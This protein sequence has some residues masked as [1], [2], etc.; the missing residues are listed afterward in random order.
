[1]FQ[2]QIERCNMIVVPK[3]I[4][5][6]FKMEPDQ[7]LKVG[8]SLPVKGSGV[9]YFYAK[10]NKEGRIRIPKIIV[11]VLQGKEENLL[12]YFLEATVEPA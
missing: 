9:Q 8:V 11:M 5:W 3:M 7:I 1:M 2:C 6:Q 4:R 12:G 10:M